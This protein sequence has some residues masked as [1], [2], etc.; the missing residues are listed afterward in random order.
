MISNLLCDTL[1]NNPVTKSAD[2]L[3]Y[4]C[5]SIA[6]GFL[7]GKTNALRHVPGQTLGI[8]DLATDFI[9]DLFEKDDNGRFPQFEKYFRDVIFEKTPD[10]VL[11]SE[12]RR[13]VFSK[14]RD[15]LYRYQKAH[16]PGLH[17][18]IRNL[19]L[20]CK[21]LN[22][23]NGVL[24]TDGVIYF[25]N[26]SDAGDP[27]PEISDELLEIRLCSMLKKH[28]SIR[29]ILE[30]LMKSF[31]NQDDHA[32]SV[33]LL[34]L[35]IAI[36][37]ASHYLEV[38]PPDNEDNQP[39]FNHEEISVFADEAAQK[40]LHKLGYQGFL[41]GLGATSTP[42]KIS[43]PT[44]MIPDVLLVRAC[45]QAI[46]EEYCSEYSRQRTHF[47]IVSELVPDLEYTSWRADHRK[48]FEYLLKLTRINFLSAARKELWFTDGAEVTS[49]S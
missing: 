41:N 32:P 10:E 36:R 31:Q 14:I 16:D 45:K 40:V 1:K 9:A 43:L 19:K 8:E 18:I 6:I 11:I 22:T 15:N 4:V 34:R 27:R 29:K 33:S 42:L 39:L 48:R 25:Q 24:L 28:Q 5:R 38:Q 30:A 35:A 26:S 46:L 44:K 23:I 20:S 49:H 21:E 13:L 47:E 2:R 12:L 3:F 7:C 17:K 37:N